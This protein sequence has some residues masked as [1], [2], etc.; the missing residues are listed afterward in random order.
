MLE[1]QVMLIK[2]HIGKEIYTSFEE[3]EERVVNRLNNIALSYGLPGTFSLKKDS[4]KKKRISVICS[5]CHL[6]KGL[7]NYKFERGN[8]N[9]SSITNIRFT[10]TSFAVKNHLDLTT[11]YAN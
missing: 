7:L 10:R 3:L 1:L 5:A 4:L 8:G 9:E 11:H 6:K 2:Y